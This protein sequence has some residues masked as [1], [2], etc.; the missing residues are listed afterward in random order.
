MRELEQLHRLLPPA[1]RAAPPASPRPFPPPDPSLQSPSSVTSLC[2]V[3]TCRA[4]APSVVRGRIMGQKRLDQNL[5]LARLDVKCEMAEARGFIP[6]H[7]HEH[8]HS[9]SPSRRNA[10]K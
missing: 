9:G 2:R 3:L 7:L 6:E 4:A 5:G 10:R 8:R 1:A